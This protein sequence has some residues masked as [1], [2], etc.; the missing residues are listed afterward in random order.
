MGSS[1][2]RRKLSEIQERLFGLGSTNKSR[3]DKFS[4]TA[5]LTVGQFRAQVKNFGID[6]TIQDCA[7]LW[8]A[9]GINSSN[10]NFGEFV[11]FI[12]SNSLASDDYDSPFSIVEICKQNKKQLVNRLIE[13]DPQI[14]GKTTYKGLYEV[15]SWLGV[16]NKNDIS[17][18]AQKYDLT[19]SGEVLYFHLLCDLCYSGG[20]EAKSSSSDRIGSSYD[21]PPPIDISNSNKTLDYSPRSPRRATDFYDEFMNSRRNSDIE[22]SRTLRRY[23][24]YEN[25]YGHYG[26]DLPNERRDYYL[27]NDFGRT[28]WS[29][30]SDNVFNTVSRIERNYQRGKDALYTG[31]GR[32]SQGWGSDDHMN[33][34][35]Q[36][37]TSSTNSLHGFGA[38]SDNF[39]NNSFNNNNMDF[40]ST[41]PFGGGIPSPGSIGSDR[42]RNQSLGSDRIK[43]TPDYEPRRSPS[44]PKVL[45]SSLF[46]SPT[47]NLSPGSPGGGRGKLDP[48]IFGHKPVV[49]PPPETPVFDADKCKNAER[50]FGLPLPQLIEVVSKHVARSFKSSKAAFGKWRGKNDFLNAQ[51]LR[52][53]LARDC[54][55]LITREDANSIVQQYGGPMNMSS[56]V[57]FLSDGSKYEEQH[58]SLQ[59]LK[60][61]TGEEAVWR[62]VANSVKGYDWESIVMKAR[63]ADELIYEFR[64]RGVNI[65]SSD[66]YYITS[67]YGRSNFINAVRARL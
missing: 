21:L 46:P 22:T 15:M 20:F 36:R 14:T 57:R 51:D 35:R 58:K 53:G 16:D 52:N 17:N 26:L 12:N 23:S 11:K 56:F 61:A 29:P 33:Q 54:D 39:P 34:F 63:N 27:P 45:E 64:R 13:I 24:G 2:L 62:R 10:M 5:E 48:S 31:F 44:S 40:A 43:S 37:G 18:L 9:V 32:T 38:R 66:L 4:P 7:T 6:L 28:G 1:F 67:K 30:V 8:R 25:G 47:K 50:I 55:I 65:E 3:W 59:G 49:E 42:P 41:S 19:G 60:Q